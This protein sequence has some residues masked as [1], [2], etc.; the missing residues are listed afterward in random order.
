MF[1]PEY[2]QIVG[3]VD[4]DECEVLCVDCM[5]AVYDELDANDRDT[6]VDWGGKRER[7]LVYACDESGYYPEGLYCDRCGAAIFEAEEDDEEEEEY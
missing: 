6:F 4:F 1:G 2:V 7:C 3:G 5:L